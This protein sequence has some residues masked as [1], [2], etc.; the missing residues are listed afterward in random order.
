MDSPKCESETGRVVPLGVF[1]QN[2][3]DVLGA[4]QPVDVTAALAG[5]EN[6]AHDDDDGGLIAIG[7]IDRHAGVLRSD[8]AVQ[9]RHHGLA[10][11]F[12]VAVGQRYGGFFVGTGDEFRIGV[13][14]VVEE[15]FVEALQRGGGIGGVIF[16]AQ[17]FDHIDHV[18]GPGVIRGFDRHRCWGTGFGGSLGRS[19]R[20]CAARCRTLLR[21]G[22]G[23]CDQSGG[24]RGGTCCSAF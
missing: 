10:G 7:V 15:R 21:L 20:C 3:R 14:A 1:A 5:V 23:G 11:D 13:A 12:E 19:G 2:C 6:V 16:D 18:I 4:V 9:A 24:S 22:G 8:G 17:G